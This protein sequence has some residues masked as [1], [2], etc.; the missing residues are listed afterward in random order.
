MQYT[1]SFSLES[2]I[3]ELQ[4]LNQ[5]VDAFAQTSGLSMSDTFGLNLSLEELVSN[6]IKYGGETGKTHKIN[7]LIS[8]DR[9]QLE[10]TISDS[11]QAFDPTKAQTPDVSLSVEERAIGGLGVFLANKYMHSMRYQRTDTHNIL[12]LSRNLKLTTNP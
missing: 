4:K 2:H 1:E 8:I 11:G 12:H 7:I 10:V 6:I 3:S 9:P 5:R